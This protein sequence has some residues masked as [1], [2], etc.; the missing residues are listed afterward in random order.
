[1]SEAGPRR[2]LAP[3]ET[4]R[5]LIEATVSCLVEF[6][7]S[8]TTTQRVQD[9]AGVS[10]GALLHHFPRKP[11]LFVAAVL[12][13]AEQHGARMREL[14]ADGPG[15]GDQVVFGI[16]VLLEGMSGPLFLAGH[17]LWMA[18]R[19]D[20]V[21]RATLG[22]SEREVGRLLRE[23]GAEAFGPDYSA[24]PGFPVAFESLV[25]LLRGLAM[26]SVLRR[27]PRTEEQIL[28]MWAVNFSSMCST[29]PVP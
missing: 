3:A 1:M 16:S 24:L 4:R 7:Y 17:E 22:P 21:L 8:G 18:A 29:T 10:R 12:H 23:I 13:V 26:T 20:A 6:G 11:D 2:T 28:H 27:N 19:T 25:Q 9:C 14:L 15:S 5:R